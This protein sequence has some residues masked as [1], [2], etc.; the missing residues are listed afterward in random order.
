VGRARVTSGLSRGQYGTNV[1]WYVG[2]TIWEIEKAMRVE[3]AALISL[4]IGG[5]LMVSAQ[6]GEHANSAPAEVQSDLATNGAS[7]HTESTF[8]FIVDAPV[9]V[10]GPLFGAHKEEVWAPGWKP[11][12]VWPANPTDQLGMVFTTDVG[13]KTAVWVNTLFDLPAGRCQY[14]YVVPEVMVTVITLQWNA[15]GN[16]THVTVK[17]DR[18]ALNAT[19]NGVVQQRAEHDA[20]SGPEW[21]EQINEYLHHPTK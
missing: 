9:H 8:S 11:R 2:N 10:V 20:K 14:V 12:F 18:S 13:E 21:A 17:Y 1:P 6:N 19:A 4:C 3:V 5:S 16:G 15:R 7:A